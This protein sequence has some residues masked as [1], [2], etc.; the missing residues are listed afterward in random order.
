MVHR[1]VVLGVLPFLALAA[2]NL[3]FADGN[4]HYKLFIKR[5]IFK[6]VHFTF[7]FL[8]GFIISS[9]HKMINN[10]EITL[11]ILVL[12][13][14]LSAVLQKNPKYQDLLGNPHF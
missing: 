10:Q 8:F 1:M 5:V 6:H 12:L 7:I 3:R 4:R 11:Y 9:F 2:L 14:I 13:Q